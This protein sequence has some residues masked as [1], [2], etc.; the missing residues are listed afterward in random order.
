MTYRGNS[1]NIGD[2]ELLLQLSEGSKHAFDILYN[3]YW[4][5]VFNTA[6]KRLN[7]ME[8]AQDI[9]QDVFV[10]LWVGGPQV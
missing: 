5:L 3:R 9:A 4:K 8:R 2:H 6:F 7:N 10:Q 1:D